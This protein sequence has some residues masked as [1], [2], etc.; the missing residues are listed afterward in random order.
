M[1]HNGDVPVP[2]PTSVPVEFQDL[3]RCQAVVQDALLRLPNVVG[4]ALGHKTVGGVVTL[5]RA[6]VVLVAQKIEPSGLPAAARIPEA[7]DGIPTD[8]REVGVITAPGPVT[9]LSTH[10][11]VS[12]VRRQRPAFGGISVGHERI[13]AGTI[14][15]CCY[16][17]SAFPGSPSKY[18]IL[19]NNH[20]LANSNDAS[21]GDPILQPGGFDG[22]TPEA[23]VLGKLA[24]FVPI[25][26]GD[27]SGDLPTNEVDAAIAEV[28][29]AD[30]DR[31]VHWVGK[32]THTVLKP[33]LDLR[34]A[35]CGRTTGFTT[36]TI[37]NI[38]ATVDVNYGSGRVARFTGQVIT[39]PMSAPGDSGSLVVSLDGGAVGLLFAGS[40]LATVVN[41]IEAVS[42]LL[43][44]KVTD[45]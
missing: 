13:T 30:L 34:V 28:S 2:L 37:V 6:L 20:V 15:A 21:A 19:S 8:V 31:A 3:G 39:S 18:Y 25:K 36:G 27:G 35:K 24:R 11:A 9:P 33:D 41:P 7:V 43:E 42:R 5:E 26:F 40:S 44:I 23:D 16:D 38:N 29:L 12:M 17:A 14:G 32:P 1:P 45:G 4:V 22:G 10:E